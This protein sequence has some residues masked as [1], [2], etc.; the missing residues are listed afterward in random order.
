MQTLTLK[1]FRNSNI[2]L[3]RIILMIFVVT[4]HYNG[5][6]GNAMELC[7]TGIN[8]YFTRFTE[9]LC[10]CAVDCFMIISGFF[11]AYNTK[12][13]L[14]KI[15]DI[16]LIVIGINFFSEI[17]TIIFTHSFSF[18]SLIRCIFPENYFA[19]FYIVTYIF[20][21]FITFIF[22]RLN[23]KQSTIFILLLT[24]LFLI[25]PTLYDSINAVTG[26]SLSGMDTINGAG[27]GNAGGYTI[28]NFIVMYCIGVYINR[29]Q[30]EKSKIIRFALPAFFVSLILIFLNLLFIP[31]TAL[32]YY[33]IFVVINALSLFLIFNSFSFNA[34]VINFIS[35]ATFGVFCLH[36]S[37]AFYFL[38]DKFNIENSSLKAGGI[39]IN[40]F[41]CVL[42]MAIICY[43]IVLLLMIINSPFKNLFSKTKFYNF[44]YQFN[45]QEDLPPEV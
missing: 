7:T 21:P 28:V 43:A 14:K 45:T 19:T 24:L 2:E 25:Y 10:V 22:D 42:F 4:L 3:L 1:N 26:L 17:I 41:V 30:F 44:K 18:K 34:P 36:V 32:C 33:N 37:N 23:R 11:L 16:L 5:M 35:K 6:C 12:I 38:W 29:A 8:F 13:K 40:Y 20:S 39:I 31:Q 15:L 27:A 9:A